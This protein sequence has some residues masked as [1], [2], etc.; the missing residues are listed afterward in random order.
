MTPPGKKLTADDIRKMTSTPR[1]GVPGGSPT[2]SPTA[3]ATEDNLA[4]GRIK[5]TLDNAW[6]RP[7]VPDGTTS[8]VLLRL[9]FR[10][11]G[12]FTPSIARS[13]GNTQLDRSV[14]DAASGVR[15]FPFLPAGFVSR[16]PTIRIEFE[17]ID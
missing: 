7:M 13:S 15:A 16:H 4:L 1:V 10:A 9:D 8:A 3:A 12:S 11:D 2:G 6:C 17:L 14:L 5:T